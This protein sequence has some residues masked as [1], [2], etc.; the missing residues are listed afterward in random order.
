[1]FTEIQGLQTAL[2]GL[3]RVRARQLLEQARVREGRMQA[4][5]GLVV[6]AMERI[7]IAWEQGRLALAQ[8]YM[9]GRICEEA[10]DAV[11]LSDS[12]IAP[13]GPR[14]GLAVYKD[15]HMLG[16]R[17]VGS[18]LKSSGYR[19]VD[20]GQG[21]EAEP[22][23]ARVLEDRVPL[24]MVSVLMLHSALH[25]PELKTALARGSSPPILVAGGAPFRFDPSLGREVGADAVGTTALDA[26]RFA[27]HYVG[28]PC[29]T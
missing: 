3:D 20:Y 27:R 5:E 29:L 25:L 23:A 24:L 8:V 28:E 10:V 15:Q 7:G 17:I 14:I 16:K 4:I 12:S 22:L 11:L 18:I 21:L 1:M 26:L 13:D 9:A 6:P 2:L 19:V